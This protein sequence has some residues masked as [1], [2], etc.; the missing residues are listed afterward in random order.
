MDHPF[1]TAA[2]GGFNRQDVLTYLEEQSAQTTRQRE[3]L[4][5]QLNEANTQRD[6]LQREGEQLRGQIAQLQQSL[7]ALRQEGY[8]VS[9]ADTG[10]FYT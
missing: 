2:F 10:D 9:L 4:E 5:G 8:Q 6:A 1:R 3:E 7:D